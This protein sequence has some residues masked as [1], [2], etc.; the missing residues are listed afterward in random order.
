M[1]RH[2]WQSMEILT[3][4]L[5]K[6]KYHHSCRKLFLASA[7]RKQAS[8]SNTPTDYA[9]ARKVHSNAFEHISEYVQTFVIDNNRAEFMKSI[10]NRYCDIL[11]EAEYS[12]SDRY[13]V[14]S[15]TQKILKQLEVQ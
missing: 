10:Y 1:T 5:K 8:E 6:L 3:S 11:L 4:L 14:Q 12:S 7:E 2:A 13:T 9:S 15:L